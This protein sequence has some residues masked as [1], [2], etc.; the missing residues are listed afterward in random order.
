MKI[1]ILDTTSQKNIWF[2]RSSVAKTIK[3]KEQKPT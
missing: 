2:Q 3:F 1:P